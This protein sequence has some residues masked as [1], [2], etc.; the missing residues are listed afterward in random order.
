MEQERIPAEAF[1]SMYPESIRAIG[2]SL[3]GVVRRPLPEAIEGV[4]LGWRIVGFDVPKGRSSGPRS[5]GRAP[6]RSGRGSTY[7][8]FIL[9]ETKHIHLGFHYGVFMDDPGRV[10][11]GD[12]RQAR[13]LTF[14]PGDPIDEPMLAALVREGARVAVLSRPERLARLLDRESEPSW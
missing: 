9:P 10:L 3:R 2:E 1:L 4:R 11:H 8:C 5:N 13:W 6:G 7:F 12:V 14:V